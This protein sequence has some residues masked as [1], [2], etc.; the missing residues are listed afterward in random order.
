VLL[1]E[2]DATGRMALSRLLS[3][4]YEIV[5][6]A[7]AREAIERLEDPELHLDLLLTDIRLPDNPVTDL[8]EGVR[9]RFPEVPVV[10]MSGHDRHD[11]VSVAALRVPRSSFVPKP[12][13]VDALGAA[14]EAALAERE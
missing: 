13:D 8:V 3:D 4:R 2:D 11:P 5:D 12:I 6:A 10:F 1:V 7:S 9:A 14:I